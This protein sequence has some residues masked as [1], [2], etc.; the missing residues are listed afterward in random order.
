M[1]QHNLPFDLPVV[2]GSYRVG[3]DLSKTTWFQVGGPADVLFKPADVQDLAHFMRS[4]DAAIPVTV[5]GVGSNV[6]IRDGGIRGVVIKLGRGFVDICADA[7]GVSA[8]AAALDVH[9]ARYAADAGRAGLEFL[10]GI[11]GTMG[12][13]LAMNA[14]A[15]GTEINDVLSYLEAVD[16]SGNIR[17]L[18]REECAYSYRHYGGPHNLIFTK[19]VLR[20][21]AGSPEKI[22]ARIRQITEARE[23][24]QPVRERTGGSTFR[25]PEGAKAWEL[26]DRSGCRG[27]RMGGAQIS[28]LHCNFMINADHATA[29]DLE[30]LG[31]HVRDKVATDSGIRLQWEIKRLG[32]AR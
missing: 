18:S 29:A 15:Y 32:S 11:P 8:G 10:A 9:V 21:S 16:A 6:I 27:L 14:G 28:P 20:S 5:L 1:A 19:A 12:G 3:A 25:N 26:I 30:A 24:T 2:R 23:A 4:K 17:T 13:A 7:D 31:E 22:Q